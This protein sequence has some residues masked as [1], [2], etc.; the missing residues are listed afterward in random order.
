GIGSQDTDFVPFFGASQAPPSPES[1]PGRDARLR[2][3]PGQFRASPIR[4]LG[5]YL[6]CLTAK[7][8]LGQGCRIRGW[9]RNSSASFV[10]RV[11]STLALWLRRHNCRCQRTS[12]WYRN[13]LSAGLL[14]GTAW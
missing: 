10:I 7:R 3:P 5:S 11:H 12:T 6:G 8:T 14:V 2:A 9:G 4:A 1:V 13:A